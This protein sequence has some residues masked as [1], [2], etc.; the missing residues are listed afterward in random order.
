MCGRSWSVYECEGLR[1]L[2]SSRR[3]LTIS[4]NNGVSNWLLSHKRRMTDGWRRRQMARGGGGG[5]GRRR[6]AEGK[7]GWLKEE[8]D[9]E[10]VRLLEE[11][12]DDWRRRMLLKDEDC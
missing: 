11:K 4:C 2:C 10:G 6:I 3:I 5:K 9:V 7:E 8:E 1:V 12:E